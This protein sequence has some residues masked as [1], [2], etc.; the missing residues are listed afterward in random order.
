MSDEMKSEYDFSN[1]ERGK[2]Y[3]AGVALRMPVYLNP[4]LQEYLAA[5]AER[6]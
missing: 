6:R 5:A 2:F 1:A 4:E 3:H